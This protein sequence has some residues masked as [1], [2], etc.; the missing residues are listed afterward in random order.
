MK[1]SFIGLDNSSALSFTEPITDRP[2]LLILSPNILQSNLEC[3]S[4][5][6]FQFAFKLLIPHTIKQCLIFS[7]FFNSSA[8]YII[9]KL[10][11]RPVSSN[12]NQHLLF[13]PY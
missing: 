11:P 13:K 10:F 2:L 12:S 1:N 9:C 3:F 8:R 4:I 7:F 6:F 5:S